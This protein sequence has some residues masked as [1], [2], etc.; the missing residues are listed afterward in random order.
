MFMQHIRGRA[1]SAREH[2]EHLRS[3]PFVQRHPLLKDRD[4]TLPIGLHGE[5]VPFAKHDSLMVISWNGLLGSD[6]GR[7]KRIVFTFVRKRY[8]SPATLDRIWEIFSWSINRMAIG[9]HPIGERDGRRIDSVI[10]SPLAGPYT[11]V[12]SNVRGDWQFYVEIFAFHHW[13]GAVRM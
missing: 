11:A 4:H 10:E 12:L 1:A 13:N 7:T 6:N 9:K 8:Y 3:N 5:A 2:W